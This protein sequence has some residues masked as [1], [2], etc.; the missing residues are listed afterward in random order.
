VARRSQCVAFSSKRDSTESL[1]SGDGSG[2]DAGKDRGSDQL[3]IAVGVLRCRPAAPQAQNHLFPSCRAAV[4]SKDMARERVALRSESRSSWE[5]LPFC[6]GF[7]HAAE[8][9]RSLAYIYLC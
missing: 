3:L 1:Q 7:R 4:A 5:K 2:E 8:I 6:R 9:D